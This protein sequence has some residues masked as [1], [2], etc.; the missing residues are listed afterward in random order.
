MVSISNC[1]AC[2]VS[3]QRHFLTTKDF[4]T[5]SEQFTLVEC[6]NCSLVITSP[7]PENIELDKYYDS[8]EYIS[9]TDESKSLV[10]R[11]YQLAK[12]YNLRWKYNVVKAEVKTRSATLIDIGCG[13]GDFLAHC[14]EKG[15]KV[16]GVEPSP[17]ARELAERKT[18]IKISAEFAPR[19]DYYD[20]ITLWHV[21]EHLPELEKDLANF[22]ESLK[23]T[24]ALI[25]AV[26]NRESQDAKKYKEYWA[27][28]D[29]PRHLWH[30]NQKSM[31]VLMTR[32][33]M[34]I[35]RVIPMKLD[36]MYV[37]ILSEK[38]QAGKSSAT[39]F[40]KGITTGMLSNINSGKDKN[41]SSLVYV[42]KK[43]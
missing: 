3:R 24:G 16:E 5:S 40:I 4:T 30:F 26:P 41:F 20:A 1:P 27:G 21:L 6:E 43:R 23:E 14:M 2:H 11:L 12:K 28:Y 17:K 9:H 31:D 19:K 18:G 36:S 13:T 10:G 15:F 35:H 8:P 39:T 22:C 29:V 37:S 42:V 34:Q 38:Y 7:R 32:L 25:I 33:D